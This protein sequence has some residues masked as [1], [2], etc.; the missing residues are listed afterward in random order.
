MSDLSHPRFAQYTASS[1][2]EHARQCRAA[3]G[4]MHRVHCA[5]EAVH[6]FLAHRFVTTLAVAIAAVAVGG[7]V[8]FY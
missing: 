8:F 3:S 5:A 6:G 2:S 7:W 1:L 4:P